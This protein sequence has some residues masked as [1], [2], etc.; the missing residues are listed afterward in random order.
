MSSVDF[1]DE[2]T[3]GVIFVDQSITVINYINGEI[4]Y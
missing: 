4:I 2:F 1:I 3:I